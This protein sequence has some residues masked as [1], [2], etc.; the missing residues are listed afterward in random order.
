MKLMIMFNERIVVNPKILGGKP[1]IKGTRIPIYII[2][3][4]LRDG[5][6]FNEI[7][8]EYPR[9]TIED[10]QAVLDYSIHLIDLGCEEEITLNQEP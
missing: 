10:I 5:A 7:L 1:I 2:L 6:S 3:R 4:M 9:L 8:N